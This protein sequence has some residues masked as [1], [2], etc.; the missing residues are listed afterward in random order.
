MRSFFGAPNAKIGAMTSHFMAIASLS[1]AVVSPV[2]AVTQSQPSVAQDLP[3]GWAYPVSAPDSS[4][5][6]VGDKAVLHVPGSTAGFT[7]AQTTD[8]FAPPDWHPQEHPAMP[9]VVSKGRQPALYA[10]A[11]C[12]LPTGAGRSENASLAGLPAGYIEEQMADMKAGLRLSAVPTMT[13]AMN[14]EA[15][16]ASDTEVREA[17]AYFAG[18]RPR[19]GWIRVVESDTVPHT[20][21]IPV[22]VLAPT[23]GGALEPIGARII[24]VP[25]DVGL[26]VLRD[27]DSGYVA[28]VPKG[29]IATGRDLVVTGGNGKTIAC[30]TCHGVDLRGVANIPQIASRSPTYI[31]RQLYDFKS[32]ARHGATGALMKAPV[33]GL[34]DS[35]MISIAAYLASITSGAEN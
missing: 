29:S 34:S 11:Y 4:G 5:G 25:E 12:H 31:F 27:S 16:A 17:A 7:K 19:S 24:E 3:P 1:F 32:G 22:N 9:A 30:A 13:A 35:D 8:R 20:E 10:C 18:L 28:Y 6:A 23:P 14:A 2:G 15:V 33:A 26:A 21:V